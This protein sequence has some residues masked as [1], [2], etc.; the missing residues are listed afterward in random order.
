MESDLDE[1]VQIVLQDLMRLDYHELNEVFMMVRARAAFRSERYEM[2]PCD[3]CGRP[4]QGP[5]VYCSL[6]CACVAA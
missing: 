3:H 6:R 1:V 4:Y 5:S 2:R